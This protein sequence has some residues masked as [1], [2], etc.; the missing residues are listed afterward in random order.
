LDQETPVAEELSQKQILEKTFAFF[1]QYAISIVGQKKAKELVKSAYESVQAYYPNISLIQLLEDHQ[2]QFEEEDITEKEV[3]GLA[4]WMQLFLTTIKSIMIG[5][6]KVD[7]H[8][9]TG[10]IHDQLESLNFYEFFE[11]AKELSS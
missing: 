1:S 5:L 11:Q 7:A 9:I 3:L 10:D 6:G 8:T 2:I 4:I